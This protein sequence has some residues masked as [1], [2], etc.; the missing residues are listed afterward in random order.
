MLLDE[1][2]SPKIVN[3]SVTPGV[4]QTLPDGLPSHTPQEIPKTAPT[5]LTPESSLLSAQA[6]KK[7]T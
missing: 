5:E 4:G 6:T 1:G 2:K 7:L 3:H